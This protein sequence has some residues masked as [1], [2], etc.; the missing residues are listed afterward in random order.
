M[1][2]VQL[3]GWYY[4]QSLGGTEAYVA[5]LSARLR[6]LG[7]EVIVA[8]PDA[9]PHAEERVYLHEDVPVYR[10]PITAAPTRAEARHDVPVRGAE[11]LHAWLRRERPDLVHLHTFVTGVGPHEVRVARDAGAR[12]VAT[13]HSGSL[14]FLCQRGTLMRWGT[15]ACDGHARPGLCAACAL[16]AAGL[17]RPAADI[18]ASVPPPVGRWLGRLPGPLGTG[19]GMSAFIAGNLRRQHAMLDDLD[20]FVVL[21]GAGRDIV[22]SQAQGHGRIVLNRLGIRDLPPSAARRPR[23]PGEPLTVAYLGRFDPIKGVHDFARAIRS[24]GR[25]QRLR[26]ELRGPV[27]N[28]TD[29]AVVTQLKRLVGPDAWVT[30]GAPLGPGQVLDYLRGVDL[31]C[32]PSRTFEGGPTVALEALSVGTPVIGTRIGG[33]LEVVQDGVTGQLVPPADWRALAQVLRNVAATP[34]LVEA[35]RRAA[36]AVRAMDAVTADY[37]QLYESL[38]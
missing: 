1:K 6:R 11:R 18:V 32:C 17:P 28:T 21:T 31:L 36:P 34:A 20:A 14:G 37:L 27:T 19:L 23:Q 30:F 5:A 9:G 2:I 26:F 38:R 16:Q 22:E 8:A 13:T 3:C 33:L 12:V 35:W 4:P 15:A 24:L 29:L 10:Y 25:Q 7:H